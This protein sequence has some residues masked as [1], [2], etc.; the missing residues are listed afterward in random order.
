[1]RILDAVD[2]TRLRTQPRAIIGY[3]DITAVHAAVGSRAG[4]IT[5][6]GPTARAELSDFTRRSLIDA[7]VN[8][9]N[10]CGA[11]TGARTLRAGHATGRLAGGNLALLA[12]L[13]G[14]EYSQQFDGTILALED[15]NEAVYRLDRMLTQLK[16]S[17]AL[18]GCRAIAFGHCTTCPEDSGDGA[19][20]LDDLLLE[21]AEEL[22]IP[23][24]TGIP[25]GHITDQWT[26][27]LGAQATL[28]APGGAGEP[29]LMVES[30][31]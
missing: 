9:K 20:T 16:M 11:A 30:A 1:M 6:H 17:G 29:T 8:G 24:V 21:F 13:A 25:L 15:V 2:F 12:S 18:R 7:V 14:T 23:C 5:F 22:G 27:A 3:S 26:L 10:S 4:L 31:K 28:D 19:R